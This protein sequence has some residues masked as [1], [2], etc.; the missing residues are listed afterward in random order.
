MRVV[1]PI[2]AIAHGRFQSVLIRLTIVFMLS[3]PIDVAFSA[4]AISAEPSDQSTATSKDLSATSR[5]LSGLDAKT[6]S[7]TSRLGSSA[8][9]KR[10]LGELH[11]VQR[12][13]NIPVLA[14]ALIDPLGERVM[15]V[16]GAP[17]DVPLRWG[18]ITKTITAR[19][20]MRLAA[21][22]TVDL[23]APLYDYVD[24]QFW[25]NPFARTHPVRVIHLLEL[26][27]GFT[28]LSAREFDFNEPISLTQALAL[29]PAHRTTRWPPGLQHSYSNL[30]PGLTQLLIETVSQEGFEAVV[31]QEVFDPLQMNLATFKPL[32]T[33]PGGY[34]ADGV[35]EIPYWYMTYPAYGALNANLDSLTNFVATLMQ[36]AKQR[37][38]TGRSSLSARAG[39]EFD[40]AQ[41]IYP[42]VRRG[43]VWY[44]HGGDADG[45]RSRYAFFLPSYST[46][47][48]RGT[49][50]II[51]IN[52]DNPAVLRR[53]ESMLEAYLVPG[54]VKERPNGGDEEAAGKRIAKGAL[55]HDHLANYAGV[56][57]PA[58]V[59]FGVKRWLGG[60]AKRLHITYTPA[61]PYATRTQNSIEG[62]ARQTPPQARQGGALSY[63]FDGG[64]AKPLV[65]VKH[66][67]FRRLDDP[68]STIAFAAEDGVMYVQGELGNHFRLDKCPSY[69]AAYLSEG[70][71]SQLPAHVLA[72]PN[73]PAHPQNQ[74][75][76]ARQD[77]RDGA[78]TLH[79]ACK[80][81]LHSERP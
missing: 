76:P 57:Y 4:S 18:S 69:L 67:Q 47:G 6:Q 13:A 60:H 59:R 81:F 10:L 40:Y 42:R 53:L 49:G 41:G 19:T 27:A 32:D 78:Q 46:P 37:P 52:V 43:Q 58:A 72:D 22:D 75:V 20:V 33:L 28:D 7:K 51:N 23:D 25:H 35:T 39:F 29:D 31:R 73:H 36:E 45:Y 38:P 30:T 74:A 1:E 65:E 11:A 48:T 3:S 24:K 26:T 71:Q 66:G 12:E 79:E 64:T 8:A 55:G 80:L 62:D 68:T 5:N 70:S 61:T 21:S 56:Y 9:F 77:S 15:S 17:E 34:R 50:Y 63:Y 2:T 14:V 16:N 44:G 54:V